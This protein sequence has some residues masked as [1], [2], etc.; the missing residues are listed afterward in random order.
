MHHHHA[1]PP[2]NAPAAC[3]ALLENDRG[4]VIGCGIENNPKAIQILE[5]TL[6]TQDYLLGDEFS[7]ADVAVAS[8]LLYI[9]Q[10][11]GPRIKMER[12]PG[13][14][15]P[16]IRGLGL[17]SV[18]TPKSTSEMKHTCSQAGLLVSP[19]ARS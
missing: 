12:W 11:F 16:E 18:V 6:S 17:G 14:C 4:Q 1:P 5:K 8:Y 15:Q 19:K 7:V 9:P 10:F 3:T 2:P 13:E